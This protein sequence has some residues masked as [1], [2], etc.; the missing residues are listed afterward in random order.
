MA[1]SIDDQIAAE[2]EAIAALYAA[3]AQAERDALAARQADAK[4]A[5][6]ASLQATRAELEGIAPPVVAK[7]K[8]A[9]TESDVGD[10]A[11]ADD[12]VAPWGPSKE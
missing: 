2:R 9:K 7:S 5:E 6:L 10:S 12:D 8:P 11:D 4:E 3:E 1:S